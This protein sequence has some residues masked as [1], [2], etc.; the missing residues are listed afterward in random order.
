MPQ[1]RLM[2]EAIAL[3]PWRVGDVAAVMEGFG[4]AEIQRWHVLRIDD[5]DEARGWVA[6]WARRWD[7]EDAASWAIVGEDDEALG[8]VGLRGINLVEASAG[9]SYWVVPSARGRGLAGLAVGVIEDWCFGTLGLNRLVLDHSTQNRQSCRVA[10]KA[11]YPLEGVLRQSMLHADG[12]H[13]AHVHA[14]TRTS[15]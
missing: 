6:Q 12:W 10:E 3:R 7:E 2:D 4:S 11:G 15:G 14:R 8:Q 1:P 5:E 9:L 13:D